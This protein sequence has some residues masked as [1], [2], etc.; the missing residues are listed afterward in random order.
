M[1]SYIALSVMPTGGR[2]HQAS[3]RARAPPPSAV[4]PSRTI[5]VR[6]IVALA[7][8][9]QS[10][11]IDASTGVAKCSMTTKYD[12][13]LQSATCMSHSLWYRFGSSPVRLRSVPFHPLFG[14]TVRRTP[15]YNRPCLSS[16]AGEEATKTGNR[17]GPI[18]PSCR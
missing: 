14:A 12:V 15:A 11:L 18:D 4:K 17:D 7:D 8:G 3:R 5:M 13:V 9:G 6:Y 10:T 16:M 1:V 2:A